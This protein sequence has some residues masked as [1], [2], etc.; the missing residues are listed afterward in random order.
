MVFLRS[1]AKDEF[2][3]KCIHVYIHVYWCHHEHSQSLVYN[4]IVMSC[5]IVHYSGSLTTIG[6]CLSAL[7]M[8]QGCQVD[9][10]G[11]D[12]EEMME[13]LKWAAAKRFGEQSTAFV[14]A[15]LV[16]LL[17]RYACVCYYGNM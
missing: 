17:S 2:L 4:L 15:V 13:K 1:Q 8:F 12:T 11:N 3:Y 14:G 6:N 9:I 16:P 10:F 7:S 5:V